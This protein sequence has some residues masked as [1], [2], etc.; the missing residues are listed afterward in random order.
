MDNRLT[1][2]KKTMRRILGVIN[3]REVLRR[4]YREQLENEYVQKKKDELESNLAKQEDDE[5]PEITWE[6][7]RAKYHNLRKGVDNV[8]YLEK[9]CKIFV[10]CRGEKRGKPGQKVK[11][12]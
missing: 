10:N 1:K 8:K 12:E 6:M 11:N 4:Q 5:L 3:E 9:I 2:V 7:L